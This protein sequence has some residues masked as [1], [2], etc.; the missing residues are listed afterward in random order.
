MK[1]FAG[2]FGRFSN[3]KKTTILNGRS[4]NMKIPSDME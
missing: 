3:T 2:L 1:T 4:Q